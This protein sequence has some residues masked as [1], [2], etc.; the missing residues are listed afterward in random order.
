MRPISASHYDRFV[1]TK[2]QEL[3]NLV[4]NYRKEP[5]ASPSPK[6]LVPRFPFRF[7][8]RYNLHV[9]ISLP[10][11]LAFISHVDPQQLPDWTSRA[12][13][14]SLRTTCNMA[15]RLPGSSSTHLRR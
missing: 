11:M 10:R 9:T 1:S 8:L 12:Q 6:Q 14:P 5:T 4:K 7:R 15:A 3:D 2:K 13:Q